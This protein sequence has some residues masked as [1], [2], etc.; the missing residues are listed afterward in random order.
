M[1][2]ANMVPLDYYPKRMF[3]EKE[4]NWLF[5]SAMDANYNVIRIWGGGM[6]L[7]NKFYEL[8]D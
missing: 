2:G 7:T 3:D 6:Y 4:L 8:A 1:K 5:Q